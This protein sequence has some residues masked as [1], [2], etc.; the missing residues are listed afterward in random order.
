VVGASAGIGRACAIEAV[1]QSGR[2]FMVARR[3]EK[4]EQVIETAGR[5][6]PGAADIAKA[7]D[8]MPNRR[9]GFGG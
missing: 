6:H 4:L 2:V 1:R 7:G 3:A 5:R 9:L 8:A